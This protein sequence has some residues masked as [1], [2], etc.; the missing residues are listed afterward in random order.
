MIIRHFEVRIFTYQEACQKEHIAMVTKQTEERLYSAAHF[1]ICLPEQH[2]EIHYLFPGGG[3]FWTDTQSLPFTEQTKSRVQLADRGLWLNA[4]WHLLIFMTDEPNV[5]STMLTP[6]L[7]VTHDTKILHFLFSGKHIC[8]SNR[9]DW[10]ALYVLCN[11]FYRIIFL[12]KVLKCINHIFI[13]S[14]QTHRGLPTAEGCRSYVEATPCVC[15]TCCDQTH[16]DR[17][18]LTHQTTGCP[19]QS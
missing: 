6:E 16:L 12:K 4:P 8:K 14:L 11:I 2:S 3:L 17:S 7:W 15:H 10:F 9:K 1:T 13:A 18:I 5:A 19:P